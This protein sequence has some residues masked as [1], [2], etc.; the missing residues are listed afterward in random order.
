MSTHVDKRLYVAAAVLGAVAI[1]ATGFF[2]ALGVRSVVAGP[3][4]APAAQVPPVSHTY[5]QIELPAGTW[6]GLDADTLDELDSSAFSTGPHT[7]SLPWSSITD[8]PGTMWHSNNDGPASGLDADT[9]DGLESD[10]F[11]GPPGPEGPAGAEGPEGPEGA[12]GPQGLQGPAGP[13]G[14]QG[15]TGP[16]GPQGPTGPQGPEGPQGPPAPSAI[17]TWSGTTYSTGAQCRVGGTC[18]CYEDNLYAECGSTGAWY[19][20]YEYGCINCRSMCG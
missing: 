17:C 9:F 7:T 1:F 18:Y 6:T 14:P 13:Q 2:V 11:V 12:M 8:L 3:G 4:S 10:E 15:L 16:Q 5:D 20:F 19:T